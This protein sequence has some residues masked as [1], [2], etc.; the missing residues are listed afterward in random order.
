MSD[1]QAPQVQQEAPE[2]ANVG[3]LD[4]TSD[5]EEAYRVKASDYD[6]KEAGEGG[7]AANASGPRFE[8]VPVNWIVGTS[9]ETSA[10]VQ[11]RTAITW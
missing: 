8:N 6:I 5:K 1:T 11:N 7:N 3:W 4:N 9:G 2:D 10:D